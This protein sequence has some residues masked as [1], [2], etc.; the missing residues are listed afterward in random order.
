MDSKI[1]LQDLSNGLS[2]RKAISKKD[3]E[4]FVRSFFD[5]IQEFLV[6][7]EQVKVKGLGTFKL[8]IVDSRESVNVNT[9][10]RILIESHPKITFTPDS[11]LRD[12][13]N[14]PF[15]DFQTVILNESTST[16]EMERITPLSSDESNIVFDESVE[17]TDIEH[18][19]V[20]NQTETLEGTFNMNSN[21]VETQEKTENIAE[22]SREERISY[23]DDNGEKTVDDD[24][25]E[26][27]TED[28]TSENEVSE[29]GNDALIQGTAPVCAS[30][31]SA[32]IVHQTV[33]EM[34]VRNQNVDHQ[35]IQKVVSSALQEELSKRRSVILS[36]G[37]IAAF[38]LLTLIFMMGAFYWGY[39][40]GGAENKKPL[41]TVE[42]IKNDKTHPDSISKP[43]EVKPTAAEVAR[44]YP[45]VEGGDYWITG[46]L[47]EHIMVSGDNLYKLA[48]K[49]YGDKDLANY[50]ITYNQ[51]KRPNNVL[52][53]TKIKLPKLVKKD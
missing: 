44:N 5:V 52:L 13:V 17:N 45:Q 20:P 25:K 33:E 14:K 41:P 53:G 51:L 32:H 22:E 24:A 48:Y 15:A 2:V 11:A 40:L 28:H 6:R 49:A 3:A 1:N 47:E 34:T 43:V 36:W 35:T 18:E 10:E 4:S 37:G 9:G 46:T 19:S 21:P 39:R 23:S 31:S 42:Q 16:E 26:L 30:E 27:E 8:I 29:K 38:F 12:Q 50:I 7:D